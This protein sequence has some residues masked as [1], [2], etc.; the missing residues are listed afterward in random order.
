MLLLGSDK[1]AELLK[2]GKT[3][4]EVDDALRSET[5]AFLKVRQKYLLY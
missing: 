1:A 2:A 3:G 5:E 4:A